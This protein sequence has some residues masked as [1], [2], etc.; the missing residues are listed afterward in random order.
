M[1]I[2]LWEDIV[3]YTCL[4]CGRWATHFYAD[5]PMCCSCHQGDSNEHMEREAINVN[6]RFQRGEQL[7]DETQTELL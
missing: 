7:F 4:Y 3:G 6:S 2:T 5:V 1:P